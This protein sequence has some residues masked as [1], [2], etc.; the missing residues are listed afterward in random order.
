MIAI[1]LKNKSLEKIQKQINQFAWENKLFF[2]GYA[3]YLLEYLK[4]K[5]K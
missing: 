1:Q 2:I 3:K 5:F 4:D